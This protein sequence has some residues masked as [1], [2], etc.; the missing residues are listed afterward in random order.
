[1]PA[2]S[3]NVHGNHQEIHIGAWKMDRIGMVTGS[4]RRERFEAFDTI[5]AQYLDLSAAPQ[6]VAGVPCVNV[7]RTYDNALGMAIYVYSYEGAKSD[8]EFDDRHITYELDFTLSEDP[9]E[10]HPSFAKLKEKFGWNPTRRAFPE[11]APNG[12]GESGGTALSG[13]KKA[14]QKTS[15][16]FGVD[17]YL[18]VGA[19]FRRTYAR[20]SIPSTAMKGLG[21]IIERPPGIAQFQLPAAA[22]KRNW[23]KMAPKISKRGSAVQITEEYMLGGPRGWVKDVYAAGQLEETSADE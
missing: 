15:E 20:R 21:A 10:T 12:G 23:L 5:D 16:M 6:I 14:K 17:S 3:K 1:M 9:I 8:F 7:E 19:V 4:I 2:A 22:K 18:A 11:F 13:G